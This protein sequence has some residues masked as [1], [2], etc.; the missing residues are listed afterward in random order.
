[1]LAGGGVK[2]GYIHGTSDATATE[3]DLDPVGP[4]DLFA[5]VYHCLGIVS[6]KEIMAPGDRPIE[7]VDG[8]EVI[9]D[10][11]V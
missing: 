10:I 3:P 7:I 11:L 4:E 9:K 8:G 6:D 5:T 1:M 2:G